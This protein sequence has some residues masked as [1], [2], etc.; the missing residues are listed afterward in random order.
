MY[1]LN[2]VNYF[3][4]R[5]EF[6]KFNKSHNIVIDNIIYQPACFYYKIMIVNVYNNK[7]SA[8]KCTFWIKS[9]N[10]VKSSLKTQKIDKKLRKVKNKIQ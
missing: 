7:C 10:I 6:E 1:Y 5:L 8:L 3:K 9:W 4:F 2:Y